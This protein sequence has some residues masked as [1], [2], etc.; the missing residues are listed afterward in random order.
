M[1]T[2]NSPSG[3]PIRHYPT[4]PPSAPSSAFAPRGCRPDHRRPGSPDRPA[5]AALALLVA[6]RPA[7]S[8]P[9]P[10]SR[11]CSSPARPLSVT[12][13]PARWPSSPTAPKR[14]TTCSWPAPLRRS[15]CHREPP[16]AERPHRAPA[17]RPVLTGPAD[18]ALGALIQARSA[19]QIPAS[20]LDQSAA[21]AR[22]RTRRNRIG[23]E[24]AARRE[25]T[26][27]ALAQHTGGLTLAATLWFSALA[28]A[29]DTPQNAGRA[30][31][32]A[33]LAPRT[34]A[35][36]AVPDC[37]WPAVQARWQQLRAAARAASRYPRSGHRPGRRPPPP[38]TG[39]PGTPANG[40]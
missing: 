14:S 10:G 3:W 38:Q 16:G 13:S 17:R 27:A 37:P 28:E 29:A 23:T 40:R 18:A 5:P 4:R 6:H 39:P 33:L 11:T 19:A 34:L 30:L 24:L 8:R 20:E 22:E 26:I 2:P 9:R 35:A 1:R 36:D 31:A 25:E 7:S 32:I 15:R 21:R 12:P